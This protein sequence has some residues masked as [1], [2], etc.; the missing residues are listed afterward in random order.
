MAFCRARGSPMCIIRRIRPVSGRNSSFRI[1]KYGFVFRE[2]ARQAQA[3]ANCAMAVASA[4]P[5]T[6]M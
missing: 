2:K 4:A 6:P 5:A 1:W 3:E